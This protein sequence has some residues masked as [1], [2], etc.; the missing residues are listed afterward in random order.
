M[1]VTLIALFTLALNVS[2][3][4]A[5]LFAINATGLIVMGLDKSFARSGALRVPELVLYGVAL[6][7]GSIGI[8]LGVN[9]F[10]HKSRK[11]TFQITLVLLG[12]FQALLFRALDLSL[13]G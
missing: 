12:C 9:F 3:P 1:L 2:P 5:Y 8:L 6:I 13:R 4:R 10:R 7:G 11:P